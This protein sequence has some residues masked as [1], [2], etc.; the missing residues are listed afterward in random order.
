L[1]ILDKEKVR[2][3]RNKNLKK[4]TRLREIQKKKITEERTLF[5]LVKDVGRTTQ[6]A[7]HLHIRNEN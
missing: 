6:M 4:K 5:P 2:D 3:A 1:K 7:P